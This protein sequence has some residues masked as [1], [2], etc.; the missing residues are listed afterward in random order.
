MSFLL[1]ARRLSERIWEKGIQDSSEV[2]DYGSMDGRISSVPAAV[3]MY[4]LL[5]NTAVYFHRL[6]E[7][8]ISLSFHSSD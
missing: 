3:M 7:I 2:T 1:T 4:S 8:Y 5:P 6:Y